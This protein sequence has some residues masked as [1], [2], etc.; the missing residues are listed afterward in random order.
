MLGTPLQVAAAEVSAVV[1]V[2]VVAGSGG[3]GIAG[4][5]G[6]DSGADVGD[7][8]EATPHFSK[9]YSFFR[10]E[11]S[12]STEGLFTVIIS[13]REQTP[14]RVSFLNYPVNEKKKFYY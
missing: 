2:G 10:C 8:R 12:F 1:L 9:P 13:Q 5:S 6:G 14:N 4:G 7:N 11:F 3:D